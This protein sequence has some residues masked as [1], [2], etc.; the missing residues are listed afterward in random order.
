MTTLGWV[1]TVSLVSIIAG[2]MIGK[3][4]PKFVDEK[5][6]RKIAQI[7]Q[8]VVDEK[9]ERKIAQIRQIVVE[10]S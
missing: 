3:S 5:L 1:V 6:E 10:K 9:L 8:I 7:R 2:V 4:G